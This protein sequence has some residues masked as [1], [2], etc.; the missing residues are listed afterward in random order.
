M[1]S[2]EIDE[3]IEN[4][5]SHDKSTFSMAR[6]RIFK[7]LV[8]RLPSVN[9]SIRTSGGEI[10]VLKKEIAKKVRLMSTR[11]LIQCLPNLLPS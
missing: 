3:R 7:Y 10:A 5:K 9:D 2:K 1:S 8:D 4:F 6:D 11:K